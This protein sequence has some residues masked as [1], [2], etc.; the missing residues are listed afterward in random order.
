MDDP[1]SRALEDAPR[2]RRGE[3]SRDELS[4]HRSPH[5]PALG[6]VLDQLR[7][8]LVEAMAVPFFDAGMG[9]QMVPVTKHALSEM[10]AVTIVARK[11]E[12]AYE[13]EVSIEVRCDH[14]EPA[15]DETDTGAYEVR[16]RSHVR[17]DDA[18]GRSE[19]GVAVTVREIGGSLRLDAALLRED[20]AA[21]IRSIGKVS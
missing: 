21:A 11:T 6:I 7:G 10:G 18:R 13:A 4:H 9:V 1:L 16:A 3:E 20:L 2:P 14:A 19:R 5:A 8:Q 12:P 17:C 15:D